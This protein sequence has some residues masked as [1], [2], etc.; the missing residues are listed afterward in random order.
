M[1]VRVA[2]PMRGFST[3]NIDGLDAEINP[4]DI[5][6]NVLESVE[7]F[8]DLVSVSFFNSA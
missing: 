4:E 3:T 8:R 2:M 7:E 1:T 5:N 6:I